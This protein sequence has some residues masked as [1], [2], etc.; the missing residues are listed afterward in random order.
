MVRVPS[1]RGLERE[2]FSSEGWAGGI[3]LAQ[4]VNSRTTI[5]SLKRGKRRSSKAF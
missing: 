4:E 2:P 3:L 5:P 1:N